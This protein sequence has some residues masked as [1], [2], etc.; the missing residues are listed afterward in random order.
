MPASAITQPSTISRSDPRPGAGR[1]RSTDDG[2]GLALGAATSPRTPPAKALQ[3][4]PA[5]SLPATNAS[6]TPPALRTATKATSPAGSLSATPSRA[7]FATTGPSPD[8]REAAIPAAAEAPGDAAPDPATSGPLAADAM[9]SAADALPPAPSS[10]TSASAATVAGLL[11]ARYGS[12]S[13]PSRRTANSDPT[14]QAAGVD[15]ISV[16]IPVS[17]PATLLPGNSQTGASAGGAADPDVEAGP[18][19]ASGTT[20]STTVPASIVATAA[21][22]AA[23]GT[24]SPETLLAFP[25]GSAPGVLVPGAFSVPPNA[26]ATLHAAAGARPAARQPVTAA[27]NASAPP[28]V[29][30]Q[31][32]SA[33]SAS[34]RPAPPDAKSPQAAQSGAAP[35]QPADVPQAGWGASSAHHLLPDPTSI[36]TPAAADFAAQPMPAQ[37]GIP[38]AVGAQDPAQAQA[39]LTPQPGPSAI[40]SATPIS[41]AAA[42][43]A[44]AS[45]EP[46]AQIVPAMLAMHSAN[47][48]QN[49]MLRLTPAELGTVQIQVTRDHDGTASVSVLVERPE[50]LR[51][52]L[53]D[54]AQLQYALTQA[55]LPQDRTLS[56]QQAPA[57][58]F[59]SQDHGTFTRDLGQNAGQGAGGDPGQASRDGGARQGSAQG[60]GTRSGSGRAA[61]GLQSYASAWQTAG[62][63]ITA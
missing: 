12:G 39:V 5:R 31:P 9:T 2:F 40:P 20:V 26:A 38:Q 53:H 63:D 43:P 18:A 30:A 19:A 13:T 35:P 21:G 3:P 50:T 56:L 37:A 10:A 48:A 24:A 27:M 54:Q 11:S 17:P 29:S 55:G 41:A 49:I 42:L 36:A 52:L 44:A 58:S 34:S 57:G 61:S 25:S 7:G 46:A 16:S 22:D 32:V 60:Q 28:D 51:L 15:S 1:G 47:G 14:P 62:I 59:A 6:A 23:A 45:G 33:M 8:A 4:A